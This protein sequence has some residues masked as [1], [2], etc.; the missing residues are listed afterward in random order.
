MTPVFSSLKNHSFWPPKLLLVSDTTQ[1]LHLDMLGY[2]IFC[3][4]NTLSKSKWF[5]DARAHFLALSQSE[6]HPLQRKNQLH[7]YWLNFI[8]CY[9]TK[10]KWT[11]LITIT[12]Y[13]TKYIYVHVC[14]CGKPWVVDAIVI[15]ALNKLTCIN[16]LMSIWKRQSCYWSTCSYLYSQSEMVKGGGRQL[17]T[18]NTSCSQFNGRAHIWS[19]V[20]SVSFLSNKRLGVTLYLPVWSPCKCVLHSLPWIQAK[21]SAANWVVVK[22]PSNWWFRGAHHVL[23]RW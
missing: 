9:L 14:T 4:E 11:W 22:V 17:G 7:N 15:E 2:H 16:T 12:F 3:K 1:A 8:H 19:T 13:W 6:Q 5:P 21:H 23:H 20:G 18:G 10:T